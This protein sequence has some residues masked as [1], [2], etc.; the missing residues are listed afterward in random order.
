[1]AGLA[2]ATL[3]P[4][5]V[6]SAGPN[7]TREIVIMEISLSSAPPLAFEVRRR[8]AR[9]SWPQRHG[10]RASAPFGPFCT[11]H[12]R[13]KLAPGREG[14]SVNE[15]EVKVLRASTGAGTRSV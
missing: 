14:V 5:H 1:M 15:G 10:G 8:S 6:A 12:S 4:G 9:P 3:M 11:V 2:A 7:A 13:A